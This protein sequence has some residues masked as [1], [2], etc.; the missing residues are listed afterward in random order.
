[1]TEQVFSALIC[2]QM[3]ITL[4][5]GFVDFYEYGTWSFYKS[6]YYTSGENVAYMKCFENS[7][8]VGVYS[9]NSNLVITYFRTIVNTTSTTQS[10]PSNTNTT[11]LTNLT[12]STN[13]T[14][15]TDLTNSTNSTNVTNLPIP[16]NQG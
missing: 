4:R 11:S 14:N 7:T 10:T 9:P 8:A 13:T 2:N 12:N 6:E 1:M 5:A 15:A 16:T 3:L